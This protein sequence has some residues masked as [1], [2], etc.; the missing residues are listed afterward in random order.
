MMTSVSYKCEHHHFVGKTHGG[1]F[2]KQEGVK[3]CA[4][5]N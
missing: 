1:V 3:Q 5:S 4:V 2:Y